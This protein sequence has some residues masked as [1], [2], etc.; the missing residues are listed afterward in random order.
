ML[1]L[2]LAG[3]RCNP[4]ESIPGL[5]SQRCTPG[6]W[7]G[8]KIARRIFLTRCLFFCSLSSCQ[9]S[10]V[11][12]LG[13]STRDDSSNTSFKALYFLGRVTYPMFTPYT[14][15]LWL[16]WLMWG[17]GRVVSVWFKIL[18]GASRQPSWMCSGMCC[19]TVCCLMSR[20]VMFPVDSE[21]GKW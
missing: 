16:T 2:G 19:I 12:D 9:A 13:D 6:T 10:K 20:Y 1:H 21:I 14:I 7:L 15:L 3:F 17:G 8:A 18:P 11:V 5:H 4:Y